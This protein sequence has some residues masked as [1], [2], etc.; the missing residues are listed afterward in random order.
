M[1]VG[2]HFYDMSYIGGRASCVSYTDVFDSHNDLKYPTHICTSIVTMDRAHQIQMGLQ[3][4]ACVYGLGL[5]VRSYF[6][7]TGTQRFAFFH[8]TCKPS[9]ALPRA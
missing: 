1:P 6:G 7:I 9:P 5:Y 3:S 8:N 4:T 2:Y